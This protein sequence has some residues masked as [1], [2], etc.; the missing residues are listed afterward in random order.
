MRESR[1]RLDVCEGKL[2]Y[3][4]RTRLRAID[5]DPAT[6]PITDPLWSACHRFPRGHL[7]RLI[8]AVMRAERPGETLATEERILE[9][10]D[11]VA[12]LHARGPVAVAELSRALGM[13]P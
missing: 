2:R 6:L 9:L 1:G 8:A 4:W 3:W 7:V 11:R 12:E 5:V 10:L 13:L